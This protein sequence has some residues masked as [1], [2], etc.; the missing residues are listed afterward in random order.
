MR[1]VISKKRTVMLSL[2]KHLYR[3]IELLTLVA[4]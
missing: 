2:S 3:I 4:W 1:E